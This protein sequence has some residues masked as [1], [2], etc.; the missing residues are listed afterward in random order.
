MSCRI[1]DAKDKAKL[2]YWNNIPRKDNPFWKPGAD[3]IN[4]L[5]EAWDDEWD[6]LDGNNDVMVSF[7]T[8]KKKELSIRELLLDPPFRKG[9]LIKKINDIFDK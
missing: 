6:K 4:L 9:V 7:Q 3:M 5:A 8:M 2:D 1:C